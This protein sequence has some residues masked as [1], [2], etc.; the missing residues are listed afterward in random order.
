MSGVLFILL[1]FYIC[2][3]KDIIEFICSDSAAVNII[4]AALEINLAYSNLNFIPF[5]NNKIKYECQ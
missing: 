2:F 4:V 5:K 3:Q 1:T